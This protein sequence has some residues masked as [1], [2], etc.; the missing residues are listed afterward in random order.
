[1]A[2]FTSPYDQIIN[3]TREILH[4]A[5]EFGENEERLGTLG[6]F[7][8]TLRSLEHKTGDDEENAT[9]YNRKKRAVEHTCKRMMSGDYMSVL[10][11]KA[12][13]SDTIREINKI[14][15]QAKEELPEHMVIKI[16][17]AAHDLEKIDE[18]FIPID[19]R[20]LRMKTKVSSKVLF[21]LGNIVHGMHLYMPKLCGCRGTCN[22]KDLFDF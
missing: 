19:E 20:V 2:D 10:A 7:Q 21:I 14:K 11:E 8:E 16:N 18:L 9:V 5:N 22:L 12:V 3:S 6:E 17:D 13:L 1:M 15:L 4:G